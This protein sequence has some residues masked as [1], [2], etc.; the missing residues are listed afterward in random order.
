MQADGVDASDLAASF[1]NGI[2]ASR[3][4]LNL[5]LFT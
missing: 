4:W 5:Y 2:K 3:M 1:I